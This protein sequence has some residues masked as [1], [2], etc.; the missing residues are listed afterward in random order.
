MCKETQQFDVEVDARGL[1][2]PL[3]LLRAKLALNDMAVGHVLKVL[4][5]DAGS[6]RDF[7]LICQ[8]GG[9]QPAA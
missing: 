4:A 9:T 8:I 7:S 6:Q 5:T 2:C 1:A 3:P